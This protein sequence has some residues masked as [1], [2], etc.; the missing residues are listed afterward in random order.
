MFY[1]CSSLTNTVIPDSVT[2]IG[3]YAFYG[4]SSLTSVTI[5]SGVTSI[6]KSA[7]ENCRSLTSINIPDS[8]TS[9]GERAFYNCNSLINIVIPDNVTSIGTHAF[10]GCTSLDVVYYGGTESDWA[11][12]SIGDS[13]NDLTAATRYYYSETQPT[14]DGNFWHYAEDGVTPVIW[15]KET[16]ES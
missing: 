10:Y 6:E 12:I 11:E 14:E 9:I 3:S 4:C 15:T 8:V 2:I 5:G 1:N 13:N 16:D 7:F